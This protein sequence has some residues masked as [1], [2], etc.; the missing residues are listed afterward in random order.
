MY[1]IE[2]VYVIEEWRQDTYKLQ[3]ES[4]WFGDNVCIFTMQQQV[5]LVATET[6]WGNK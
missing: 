6:D 1:L 3:G 5:E 4:M 2:W